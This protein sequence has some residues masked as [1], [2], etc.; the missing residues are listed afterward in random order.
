M[1]RFS[2]STIDL[3]MRELYL[4]I[5]AS[6]TELLFSQAFLNRPY[7]LQFV[8]DRYPSGLSLGKNNLF[9][10]GFIGRILVSFF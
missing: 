6:Q 10:V 3:Q 9:H 4:E 2:R 5:V 1:I 8:A 7:V